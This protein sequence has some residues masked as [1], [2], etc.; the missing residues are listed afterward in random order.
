MRAMSQTGLTPRDGFPH[1]GVESGSRDGAGMWPLDLAFV[2]LGLM[3]VGLVF[4]LLR[5]DDPR[6]SYNAW[7]YVLGIPTVLVIASMLARVLVS[8]TVERSIQVGFLLSVVAH[9][10]LMLLAVNV[11]LFSGMWPDASGEI[12]RRIRDD[13]RGS[14]FKEWPQSQERS[15]PDYL[16]PVASEMTQPTPADI[17]PAGS[18]DSP[19]ELIKESLE[20][21]VPEQGEISRAVGSAARDE[22]EIAS[23]S[24]PVALPERDISRGMK[25][26]AIEVPAEPSRPSDAAPMASIQEQAAQIDASRSESATRIDSLSSP[27]GSWLPENEINKSLRR[28]SPK[29]PQR[30]ESAPDS[31][32]FPSADRLAQSQPRTPLTNRSLPKLSGGS[33]TIEVPADADSG[34][35]VSMNPANM[36]AETGGSA[37]LLDRT[38]SS[39]RSN[40]QSS[41][42]A[43][44][45][46]SSS[47]SKG[48]SNRASS[49]LSENSTSKSMELGPS[50]EPSVGN[51]TNRTASPKSAGPKFDFPRSDVGPSPLEIGKFRRTSPGEGIKKTQV[52]VPAPAFKLRMRRNEDAMNQDLQAMGPLGPKTEEA[53]ER[54]LEF[55]AKHQREDGSWRLE[56]FGDEPRLRSD[57]AA[58]ALALLSFQGA[59]YS[60]EQFRYQKTCKRAI[61]WLIDNQKADGDLYR[62]MDEAS[63][64]NAWIYSH[65]IASLALCEA[66]GMT[67]DESIRKG[68][69]RSIDF[70]AAGQ[71]PSAGGWRYSPRIGSDTS[72]TGWA[73][74][75]LKS[76][77]LAG[78]KVPPKVFVGISKWLSGSEASA[79]ERYLYRYNWLA[80]TPEA[81]HGR[82]PTPVMTSVGLLMRFYLGWRRTTP[83]M[84]RGTDWLL[85]RPPSLGTPQAPQRDTYYWYYASQVM[86]HMGGER[87]QKWYRTLDPILID[88]QETEGK[89]AGSWNPSGEIPDAWGP[90]AGRLYVTTM[91]L[92]SL[93]VTYRHL[94]IY[95]ATAQ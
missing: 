74:M 19:L 66:Y 13:S 50:I 81:I 63:D 48:S 72:V 79:Q 3:I 58:T 34:S 9:L 24:K 23:E 61:D 64:L 8:E 40:G 89:Y 41:N 56:D 18:I 22:P 20:A 25:S 30:S 69:Q 5:F 75:A 87:W 7:T 47:S 77:E 80:N 46:E 67:Q 4:R 11:V 38:S 1:E 36:N 60:H 27:S 39:E 92:L 10:L 45:I 26:K 32:R 29:R 16:K 93:E 84:Q 2:I 83:D 94:P 91:N 51:L 31:E 35:G 14:Q 44:S 52:A 82:I 73:M 42:G 12:A 59:G 71:D 95:E 21:S 62:P 57:T 37:A 6:W 33:R 76:A 55:L 78:L 15:Q 90:Y 17:Q 65:A 68:A 54:G 53:I 43:S 28:S 88:T 85:D 86:F 49:G 70:L